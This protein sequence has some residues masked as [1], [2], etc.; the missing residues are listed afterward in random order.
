MRC[1]LRVTIVLKSVGIRKLGNMWV[2][3]PG[4]ALGIVEQRQMDRR[5]VGGVGQ[6][7]WMPRELLALQCALG[8]VACGR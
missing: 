8:N 1:P 3:A 6:G 5:L 7:P 2:G 4:G